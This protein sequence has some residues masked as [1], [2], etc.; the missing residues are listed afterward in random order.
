MRS[1]SQ[2][3][4]LTE[5]QISEGMDLCEAVLE[6]LGLLCNACG[7][8]LPADASAVKKHLFDAYTLFFRWEFMY[9][10]KEGAE[11]T[12]V[13]LRGRSICA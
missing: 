3:K 2:T 8:D 11:P 5:G 10:K 4:M 9:T 6:Q 13:V 12:L 1:L 7:P